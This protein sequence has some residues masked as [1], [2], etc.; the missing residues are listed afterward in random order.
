MNVGRL[1]DV[2]FRLVIAV[3]GAPIS[4]FLVKAVANADFV[5]DFYATQPA[6]VVALV[7]S[8]MPIVALVLWG[9][10]VFLPL[11]TEDKPDM[12]DDGKSKNRRWWG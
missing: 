8:G 9:I 4:F 11:A 6:Y 2:L 5:I 12:T 1:A 3:F 7:S 10:W